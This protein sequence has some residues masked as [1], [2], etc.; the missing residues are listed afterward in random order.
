MREQF[1]LENFLAG[2][3]ER[4][5]IRSGEEVKDLTYF[6][7]A[8]TDGKSLVGVVCDPNFYLRGWDI[9]GNDSPFDIESD[10][11]LFGILKQQS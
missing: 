6:P 1:N 4:F 3:Y 10:H 11:D 9:Y 2:K 5:E 7:S 8:N